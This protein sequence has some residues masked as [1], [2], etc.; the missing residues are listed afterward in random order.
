MKWKCTRCT[1]ENETNHRNCSI[2]GNPKPK[3]KNSSLIPKVLSKTGELESY[4]F[5]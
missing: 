3:T 2:C 5:E 4:Y 1:L